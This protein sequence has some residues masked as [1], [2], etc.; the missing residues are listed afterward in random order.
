MK[1]SFIKE[2]FFKNGSHI[3]F[4]L[5][6]IG[7]APPPPKCL[8]MAQLYDDFLSFRGYF[9]VYRSCKEIYEADNTTLQSKSYHLESGSHYCAMGS[10]GECGAGGWTL[11]MSIDG[12]RV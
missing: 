10:L 8:G 3:N 9:Q 4:C 6:N 11:A 5:Q 7:P 1:S 12:S 2:I